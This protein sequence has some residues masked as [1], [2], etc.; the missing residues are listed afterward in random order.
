MFKLKKVHENDF[1]Y[2]NKEHKILVD[3]NLIGKREGFLYI[4]LPKNKRIVNYIFQFSLID[5]EENIWELY[6]QFKDQIS[7]IIELGDN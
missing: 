2:R 4:K 7:I 1:E 6:V 5:I 3:L